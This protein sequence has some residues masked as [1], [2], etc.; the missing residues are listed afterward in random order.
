MRYIIVGADKC[1]TTALRYHLNKHEEIYCHHTEINFFSQ[2]KN[3]NLGINK[4]DEIFN[5]INKTI[6]GEKSVG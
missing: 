5:G 6:Y 1:G 3:Y 2:N 4:Y